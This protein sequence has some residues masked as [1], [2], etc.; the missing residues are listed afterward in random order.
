MEK[1]IPFE[2]LSK[3]E[4]QKRNAAWRGSWYGLNPVTRKPENSKA[5]N[6]RKAQKWSNGSDS[7]PFVISVR[8]SSAAVFFDYSPANFERRASFAIPLRVQFFASNCPDWNRE[9]ILILIS[10]NMYQHT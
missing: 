2:K 9:L 6:R 1:F 5:Y 3:K 7:V 4:Q 8:R 10:I